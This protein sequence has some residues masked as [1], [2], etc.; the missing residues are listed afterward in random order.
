MS[1]NHL[2]NHEITALNGFGISRSYNYPGDQRAQPILYT[3]RRRPTGTSP[4]AKWGFQRAFRRTDTFATVPV[5]SSGAMIPGTNLGLTR[6]R[7][8]K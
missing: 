1:L 5:P 7:I 6:A 8:L 2:A 3:S 4:T